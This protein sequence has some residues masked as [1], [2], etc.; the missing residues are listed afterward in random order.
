TSLLLII[1]TIAAVPFVNMKVFTNAM[2]VVID[3]AIN[4]T[5]QNYGGYPDTLKNDSNNIKYKLQ[6]N[7][8]DNSNYDDKKMSSYNS[9][10]DDK[11]SKYPTRDKIYVC[12]SGPFEGFFVS[13][14]EFCDLR[15]SHR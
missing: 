8:N 13:S 14:V 10:Y 7:N 9:N 3:P 11:N 6:S 4:A 1:L 2:A 5:S 15:S 12:Q